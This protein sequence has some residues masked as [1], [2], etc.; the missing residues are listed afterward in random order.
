MSAK[1]RLQP[2][3]MRKYRPFADGVTNG[4]KSTLNLRLA[5]GLG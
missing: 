1:R 2:A 4:V 3:G 5:L